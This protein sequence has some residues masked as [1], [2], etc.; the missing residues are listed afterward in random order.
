[1]KKI[2]TL[3]L[4]FTFLVGILPVE[5]TQAAIIPI[6]ATGCWYEPPESPDALACYITR[7]LSGGVVVAGLMIGGLVALASPGWGIGI[8]AY[9]IVLDTDGTLPLS[10]V[11]KNL[12]QLFPQIDN[13]NLISEL[14]KIVKF[15]YDKTG[16]TDS[17]L[18][19]NPIQVKEIL[20]QS[21]LSEEEIAHITN[22]LI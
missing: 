13:Q 15:T 8:A 10:R 17:L 9:G 11:E 16:K 12:A 20:Q 14:A 18:S 5:K 2:F 21:D 3:L 1:M 7:V 19:I 22:A 4:L 6:T